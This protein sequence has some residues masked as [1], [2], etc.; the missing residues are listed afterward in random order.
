MASDIE[1]AQLLSALARKKGNWG[2]FYDRLEHFK[3]FSNLKQIIKE[4][5]KKDW[6]F[7]HNKPNFTAIS[8]N[9]KY[10]REIIEFIE[11]QMP[12][13]KGLIK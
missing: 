3:R 12:Y 9:T 7:I 10:K 1:K 13:L 11:E 2:G 6:I 4:L 5:S 8:L